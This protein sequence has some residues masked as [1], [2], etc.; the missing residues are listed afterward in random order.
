[1][2]DRQWTLAELAERTGFTVQ[3]VN[4]LITGR[5]PITVETAA[6]LDRVLGGTVEF[7][8]AREAR[9]RAALVRPDDPSRLRGCVQYAGP[10]LS[11]QDLCAPVDDPDN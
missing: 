11:T 5:T 3:Q 6:G 4:E 8:L 9:Y 2:D 10:P 1:M 7:W